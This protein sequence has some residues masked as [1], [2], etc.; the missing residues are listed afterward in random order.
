MTCD[1]VT[2]NGGWS[3]ILDENRITEAVIST[4]FFSITS[5][6]KEAVYI[7]IDD[8]DLKYKELLFRAKDGF[9]LSYNKKVK[10]SWEM[11]GLIL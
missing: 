4:L 5:N 9:H 11:D 7:F 2:D 1:Q 8:R 3:L 10:N 6:Y